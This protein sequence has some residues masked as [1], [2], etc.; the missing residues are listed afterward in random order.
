MLH[1]YKCRKCEI[2]IISFAR[3]IEASVNVPGHWIL[4]TKRFSAGRRWCSR[5]VQT[6]DHGVRVGVHPW[7]TDVDSPDPRLYVDAGL[8]DTNGN[9]DN[10][11]NDSIDSFL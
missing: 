6:Y 7:R 10:K 9:P 1:A 3:S 11:P 8:A 4:I 2:L 5:P